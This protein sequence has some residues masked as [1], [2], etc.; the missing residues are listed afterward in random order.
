MKIT[1]IKAILMATA[2]LFAAVIVHFTALP[3]L[4]GVTGNDGAVVV[5]QKSDVVSLNPLLASDAASSRVYNRIFN[6][7]FRY[8]ENLRVTTALADNY[9]I[10]LNLCLTIETAEVDAAYVKTI[11][12]FLDSLILASN[13]FAGVLSDADAKKISFRV[14]KTGQDSL[15]VNINT[16]NTGL[17]KKIET[18]LPVKVKRSEY[19]PVVKIKLKSGVKWHDGLPFTAD[20][21]I[22]TFTVTQ[23]SK[24][25]PAYDIYNISSIEKIEK[26]DAENLFV[27]FSYT[28]PKIYDTLQIPIVPKHRLAGQDLTNS[29]FNMNPVGTGPFKFVERSFDDYIILDCNENYFEKK[30]DIKRLIFRTIPNESI[31]FL[32]L[33]QGNVDVMQLK[34]DQFVK[35][36]QDS[37]F[38]KRFARIK[39]P[40]LEYSY[41][42]WNLKNRLF[43]DEKVRVALGYA[44][45]KNTLIEK[46]LY[47]HGQ[48]CKGPFQS[49]SWA[50]DPKVDNL[51]ADMIK[52]EEMLKSSGWTMNKSE[53][54]LEKNFPVRSFFG[55]DDTTEVVKFEFSLL[56]SAGNKDRELCA[57][58]IASELKRIGIKVNIK[59]LAWS[60]LIKSLDNKTFDA[61]ILTWALACDPDIS[62]VW[63]SSQIPDPKNGKYGLNSISYSNPEVDRLLDEAKQTLD[64][65]ERKPKY[66]QVHRT[67]MNEQPYTF[68]YI[69]DTLYAVSKRVKIQKLSPLGILHNIE[70]WD[71]L[72]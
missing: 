20:D 31:M 41:I 48:I 12:S 46:T 52:S 15:T 26:I 30:P 39:I 28:T 69:A 47:N 13:P 33:L 54:I 8:D 5:A 18:M 22:F 2:F 55:Y 32:E 64:Q 65:Q 38:E 6:G 68:L 36:T 17:C 59:T 24:K 10:S 7:L 60:E 27:V 21:V 14:E 66:Q 72:E 57:N 53:Q 51:A 63:H 42:G 43:A 40:E 70:K 45:D 44:I 1:R 11:Q 56:I 58:F 16:L 61:F 62:N 71:L 49:S 34:S 29:R 67:I 3:A 37:E 50:C 4:S 9:E 25:I 35:F 23:Q 19:K